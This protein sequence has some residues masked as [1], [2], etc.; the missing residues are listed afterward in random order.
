MVYAWEASMAAR[1]RG[2]LRFPEL[3]NEA[4]LADWLDRGESEFAK[5]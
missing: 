5:S 4:M 2:L 1:K 3:R